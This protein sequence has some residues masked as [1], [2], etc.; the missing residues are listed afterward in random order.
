MI[1][2]GRVIKKNSPDRATIS[3][4]KSETCAHCNKC[5]ENN[6]FSSE[7]IIAIDANVCVG[8]EVV[9]EANDKDVLKMGALIY[10]LPIIF[11]F[12]GY[13]VGSIFFNNELFRILF[14]FIGTGFALLLI[15]IF[16]KFYGKILSS[17]VIIKE[18][19]KFEE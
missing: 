15:Y 16:D 5:G 19:I 6:K 9:F 7:I 14:S 1:N 12:I 3:V 8:D 17:K 4:Y 10:L 18:V 11:F 2:R 13:Y